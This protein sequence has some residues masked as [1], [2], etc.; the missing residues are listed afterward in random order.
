MSHA[1]P[2]LQVSPRIFWALA[3]HGGVG[4]ECTFGE[5]LKKLVPSLDWAKMDI[6]HRD[7]KAPER[8][9]DFVPHT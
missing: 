5:A 1:H 8:F 9:A 4:P 2:G 6:D 3:R 7:R